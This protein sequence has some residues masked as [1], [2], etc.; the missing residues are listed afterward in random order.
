MN[1]VCQSVPSAC[2]QLVCSVFKSATIAI[3]S[4]LMDGW[5]LKSVWSNSDY[6]IDENEANFYF[7]EI[8]QPQRVI[9]CKFLIT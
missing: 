8:V 2:V 7:K 9:N 5:S 6:K 1:Q 3:V 4:R